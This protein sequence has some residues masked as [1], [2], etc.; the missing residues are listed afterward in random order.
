MS[1]SHVNS[2]GAASGEAVWTH[3]ERLLPAGADYRGPDDADV[4]LALL[5]LH[6]VLGQGFGV[7][8]RVGPVA[9][10]PRRDV[11]H[12]AVVHPPDDRKSMAQS[13]VN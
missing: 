5:L 9:D 1:R 2:H 11:T 7:G 6:H 10:E 13:Q 8:V 3:R 12:D 4:E